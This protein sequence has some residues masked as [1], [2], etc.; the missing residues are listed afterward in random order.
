[1]LA[2][3]GMFGPFSESSRH[4]AEI[5]KWQLEHSQRRTLGQ[6]A[7]LGTHHKTDPVFWT[8]VS[9]RERERPPPPLHDLTE[10]RTLRARLHQLDDQT[11]I[12]R[13]AGGQSVPCSCNVVQRRSQQQIEVFTESSVPC[14]LFRRQFHCRV[15]DAASAGC[16]FACQECKKLFITFCAADVL[17]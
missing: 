14:E 4:I 6:V 9:Q 10:D 16:Y 5:I 1:M 17:A 7:S 8:A 2:S 13:E 15:L 11:V 12:P 3:N